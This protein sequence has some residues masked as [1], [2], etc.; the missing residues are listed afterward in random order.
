MYFAKRI[1]QRSISNVSI[2]NAK[3]DKY[4]S[5]LYVGLSGPYVSN[6][7]RI[8]KEYVENKKKWVNKKGFI[9]YAKTK[10]SDMCNKY[11]Y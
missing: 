8:R 9:P 5:A 2:S 7:E 6:E 4:K 3:A 10:N 1:S 11:L